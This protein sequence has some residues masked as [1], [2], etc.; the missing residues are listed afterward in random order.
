[1]KNN[2]SIP[3]LFTAYFICNTE[4]DSPV[5]NSYDLAKMQFSTLSQ[6]SNETTAQCT[7]LLFYLMLPQLLIL[8]KIS[9]WQIN[10]GKTFTFRKYCFKYNVKSLDSFLFVK[11]FQ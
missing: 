3:L 7:V 2:I 10:K 1:M 11:A 5:K 9:D 6:I 4:K 8:N